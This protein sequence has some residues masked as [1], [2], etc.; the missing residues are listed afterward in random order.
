MSTTLV[1]SAEGVSALV[2]TL[3]TADRIALDTEGNSFHAYRDR[4]C[5]I[6]LSVGN[7]PEMF[8][9]DPLAVDPSPL[10]EIFADPAHQLVVHGGDF[11]VRSLRRDFKF[12]FGRL[13]D[14]MLAAQTLRL[15]ELGLAA[16]L[17]TELGVVIGKGEQRSDWGR[18]PL[19]SEQLSYAAEDVRHLLPLALKLTEQLVSKGNL[20]VADA[21]FEKLRHL[22]A[23]ENPFDPTAFR[24][25]RGAR[26]LSQPQLSVLETL[27]V[28]RDQLSRQLD[29]AP[30]KVIGEQAMIE[31]ARRL[32]PNLEG[33]R[34]VPGVSD[35]FVRQLGAHVV[36]AV[37]LAS[38]KPDTQR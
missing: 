4:V 12:S 21:K 33:L 6:Q 25:M 8:L 30:F 28:G 36:A 3:R 20:P 14:T 17:R 10:G 22:V 32:P 35:H 2:E 38:A 19:R 13:F 23:R 11:D 18:R 1:S 5:L 27:W 34:Q 24:K 26:A 29:R 31:V 9:V 15:P 37:A 16:L 7:S